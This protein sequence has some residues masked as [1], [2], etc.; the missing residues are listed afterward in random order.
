MRRSI[1]ASLIDEIK[2]SFLEAK[3]DINNPAILND[4][5]PEK[6]DIDILEWLKNE[7]C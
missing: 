1:K 3:I 7:V 2:N 5:E 4:L 6:H